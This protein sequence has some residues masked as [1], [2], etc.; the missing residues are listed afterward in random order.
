MTKPSPPGH[1]RRGDVIAVLLLAAVAMALSA[2]GMRLIG[3]GVLERTAEDTWFDSDVA[4]VVLE[5]TNRHAEHRRSN[6]H[7]LFSLATY[8]ATLVLRYGAH[9]SDARATALFAIAIAG[10]WAA[11]L[12]LLL[13]LLALRRADAVLLTLVGVTSAAAIFWLPIRETYGLGSTTI[14]L[15]LVLMAWARRAKDRRTGAWLLAGVIAVGITVTNWMVAALGAWALLPRRRALKVAVGGLAVAALLLGF[16]K[17]LMPTTRSLGTMRGETEF[18]YR[19]DARRTSD[20]LTVL[21][22]HSVVAPKIERLNTASSPPPVDGGLVPLAQN[23]ISVQTAPLGSAGLPSAVAT[24]AWLALF[25][26]G[27]V[28]AISLTRIDRL[29]LVLLLALA[30]QL[31]LHLVYGAETFLYALHWTPLL[32]GIAAAAT[33]TR[34]RPLA[35]ALATLVLVLGAT[36]NLRQLRRAARLYGPERQQLLRE[37]RERPRDPWP[38]GQAHV[39]LGVPGSEEAEKAYL[40]PGGSFSPRFASFGV[41]IWVRDSTGALLATSDQIPLAAVRTQFDSAPGRMPPPVS[42]ETPYYRARWALE[43]G[44]WRLALTPLSRSRLQVV[45]RSAGPAGA[46]VHRLSWDGRRLRVNDNWSVSV[47]PSG[48]LAALGSEHDAGWTSA[49]RT[50]SEWSGEEGWGYARIAIAPGTPAEIALVP[51]SALQRRAPRALEPL[52]VVIVPDSQFAA[53]LRSAV[54]HLAMSVVRSETRSADPVNVPIPWQRTAAYTV[55]ALARAGQ[56]SLARELSTRLAEQD[57]YGGF[58]AEADA[59]GLGIWAL[60]EVAAAAPDSSYD[61]WLW[62]HVRR[63]AERILTLLD[64]RTQVRA[65]VTW[66]IVPRMRKLDDPTLVADSAGAGLI[67]GRMDQSLPLL[68]VNAT[69]YAGLVRA[70]DLAAR[71]GYTA[72]AEQYR[73]RAHDL[74]AAWLAAFRAPESEN[75]R[76]TLAVLW[77]TGAAD[78]PE[79]RAR[80]RQEIDR[81][82]R[83]E[84]DTAGDYHTRPPWT[85]FEIALAH[86]SLLLGNPERSW[87]ILEWFWQNQQ[88]P[89][90]YTWWEGVGEGNTFY[91]WDTARGWVRPET[92]TPHYWTESELVLLQMDMLASLDNTGDR[93]MVVVGRGV[94]P[95]WLAGPLSVRGLRIAGRT[96]DWSWNRGELQVRVRGA[97]LAV[98]AAPVFPAGT[99]LRVSRLTPGHL[100]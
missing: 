44:S 62:P 73:R 96:I 54:A 28:A 14:L 36:S 16:E 85:Y 38:R 91:W 33:L 69:A 49:P 6:V 87:R 53:S 17:W 5:M 31:A 56:V 99:R 30:G 60:S 18:M 46:P 58:G 83:T 70:A 80:L 47:G 10:I 2:Y 78:T 3:P 41:S 20:V 81:K 19:P 4:R 29:W 86:Q 93:P 27:L 67:Y 95:A 72:D 26:L 68:Y 71:L 35:L 74:R 76:T 13:R 22:A 64:A 55:V 32:I 66:P 61:R 11:A 84:H 59:P 90:L 79:G 82:W 88:F 7:P 43:D 39:V 50:A 23:Q 8:P 34:L 52:P 37:M 1:S 51:D 12:Y 57:Y 63:K 75:P 42:S 89:G 9:L 21:A 98:R 97:P 92:V 24:V 40:E 48:A 45:V 25:A 94:R 65:P 77:P 15:A 100:P